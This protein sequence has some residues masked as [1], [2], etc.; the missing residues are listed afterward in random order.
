MAATETKGK[1]NRDSLVSAA[2]RLFWQRGYSATSIADLAAEADIPVGNVYYY[3]RSKADVAYAVA[4]G[5]VLDTE[6]MI[7]DIAAASADPRSRLLSLVERLAASQRSRLT[8]GCPVS[9][10]IRE[11]KQDAPNASERAV[12]VFSLISAFIATE[13]GRTGTRPAIALAVGRAAIAE[14]QGG[15]VLGS[16]LKEPSVVAESGRRLARIVGVSDQG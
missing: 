14:W 5:F 4:D 6:D 1:R 2:A 16:A 7:T 8:H 15:I 12:E 3:F 9:G 11:F 10:A 13:V